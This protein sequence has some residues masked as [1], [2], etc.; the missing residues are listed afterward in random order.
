M[1]KT[2]IK[3]EIEVMELH[4]EGMLA[5]SAISVSDEY[6]VNDP[7]SILSNEERGGSLWDD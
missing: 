3:P 2:Y 6:E 7:G 1:K 4:L 5:A